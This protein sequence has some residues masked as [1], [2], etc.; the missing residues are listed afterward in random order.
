M[1]KLT[2]ALVFSVL[3][4]PVLAGTAAVHGAQT[5]DDV[6]EK[7]LSALGG[8]AALGKITSRRSTGAITVVTPNGEIA[9]TAE[10]A[11]KA[12]NKARS[13]MTLDL[14]AMGVPEKL[15]VQQVFNGTTGW[16][17]DSMNGDTE[18]TGN[19]LDNLRNNSFPTPL[20]TYKTAGSKLDLLPGEKIAGKDVVV[21]RFTPKAGSA[22][23]LFFDAETFLLV[24][25]VATVNMPQAGGD[26]EQTGEFSDYRAV[27]GVKVPFTIV[28]ASPLQNLTIKLS[29]VEHNVPLDDAMFNVKV[30]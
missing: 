15:V 29:K 27:D 19:R 25:T 18:I 24:K 17:L 28:N 4:L 1:K 11:V 14:S 16:A 6:V 21:L 23:R 13:V 8:R 3:S 22:A 5:A 9:G 30:P 7:Y 12:P 20:L 10:I 26:I 2:L